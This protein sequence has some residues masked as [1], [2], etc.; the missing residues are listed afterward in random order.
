LHSAL[1]ALSARAPDVPRIASQVHLVEN[2][3]VYDFELGAAEMAQIRDLNR[4]QFALF[5]A[6]VLA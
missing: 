5:D 6:D 3:G 4:D 2:I 1:Q